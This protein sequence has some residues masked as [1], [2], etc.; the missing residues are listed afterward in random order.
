MNWRNLFGGSPSPADA[1]KKLSGRELDRHLHRE[2]YGTFE[3]SKGIRPEPGFIPQEGY[4]FDHYED[5]DSGEKI[6]VIV[7]AATREKLFN[8]FTELSCALAEQARDQGGALD[9]LLESTHPRYGSYAAL[10]RVADIDL[11]I[12]QSTLLDFEDLL[13][14]DGRTGVAMSS[15][16]VLSE[17][18]F[19]E[20]KLITIYGNELR[21]RYEPILR[22]FS[23]PFDPSL[24][25]IAQHPHAHASNDM[26]EQRFGELVSRLDNGGEHDENF[27]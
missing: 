6:P 3:L 1:F 10:F 22:G 21:S 23:V 11:P 14:N 5:Q 9:L 16:D 8:I 15:S 17:I 18:K 25:I 12:V 7:C 4:C 20:H 26:Y 2:I 19:C 24:T 13:V 27:L